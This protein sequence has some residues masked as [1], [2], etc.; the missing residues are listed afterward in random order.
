M[1]GDEYRPFVGSSTNKPQEKNGI[2]VGLRSLRLVQNGWTELT[3]RTRV[4]TKGE[5]QDRGERAGERVPVSQN[6]L[7]WKGK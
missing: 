3:E 7:F 4:I 1:R 5:T 2:V 6:S